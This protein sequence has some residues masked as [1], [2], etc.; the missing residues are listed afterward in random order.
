MTP[1]ADWTTELI[2]AVLGIATAVL[3]PLLTALLVQALKKL[4][5]SLDAEKTAK[6]EYFARQAILRAEEWAATRI[7]LN[8]GTT[9]AAMKLER[10]LTDLTDK[11]PGISREEAA[12]LIHA[13]LPKM[14]LGAASFIQS[15][16]EAATTGSAQ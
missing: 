3:V 15:V 13:T 10:A 4:G 16:R 11:V 1:T 14:G 2:K 8:A 5:L 9:T 12:Q 6:V 7:K